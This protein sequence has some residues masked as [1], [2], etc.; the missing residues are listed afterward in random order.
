MKN[1]GLRMKSEERRIKRG[2]AGLWS[3][4]ELPVGA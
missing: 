1:E 3:D 4:E 2:K